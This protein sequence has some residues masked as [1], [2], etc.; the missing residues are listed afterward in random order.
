MVSGIQFNGKILY[1]RLTDTELSNTENSL[2]KYMHGF[3]RTH[4]SQL[5]AFLEFTMAF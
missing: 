4:C 3:L 2:W 1:C 5:L